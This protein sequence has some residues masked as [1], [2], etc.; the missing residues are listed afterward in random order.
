M[1][2]MLLTKIE[3]LGELGDIVNVKPGYARN[4]LLP[5]AK[6]QEATSENIADFEARKAVLREELER[7]REKA[8]AKAE[9]IDGKVIEFLVGNVNEEGE[10]SGSIGTTDLV[11]KIHE[12]CGIEVERSQVRLSVGM[13]R[14]VGKYDVT[15][16]LHA[17][18]DALV[19]V[20][21][22]DK[23][24]DKK[25]RIDSDTDDARGDGG[26]STG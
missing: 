25:E 13:F 3:N 20:N 23:D 21:I 17:D 18:V 16:H 8:R 1:E 10:L 9:L 5:Y 12:V 24:A 11:V 4:Y 2:V 7:E 26:N 15:V 22:L 6:A 19:R 14:K